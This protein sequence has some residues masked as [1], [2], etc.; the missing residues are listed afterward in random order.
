MGS[1]M[2]NAFRAAWGLG[3]AMAFFMLEQT[4][5]ISLTSCSFGFVPSNGRMSGGGDDTSGVSNV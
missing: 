4:L 3:G 2:K 1:S 5:Q